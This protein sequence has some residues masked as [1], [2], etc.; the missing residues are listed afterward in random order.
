MTATTAIGQRTKNTLDGR[1]AVLGALGALVGERR[2]LAG[3]AR[4]WSLLRPL[5]EPQV[6]KLFSAFPRQFP[7]FRSC[8]RGSKANAW[9]G[10]CAKCLSIFTALY[11]FVP[12]PEIDKVVA[13]IVA[14]PPAIAER[15]AKAFAPEQK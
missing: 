2:H 1:D 15:Y 5:Y 9:C 3:E 11:P 8:N 7:V 12:G 4:F 14:T 6:V 10:E 13:M